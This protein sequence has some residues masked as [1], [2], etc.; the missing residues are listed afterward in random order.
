MIVQNYNAKAV[1]F[2]LAGSYRE[3]ESGAPVT[4]LALPPYGVA[5]LKKD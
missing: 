1:S 5:F 3:F 2:P 4:E